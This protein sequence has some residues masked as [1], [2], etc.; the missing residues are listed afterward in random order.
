MSTSV[1]IELEELQ[2]M[3][4]E[5]EDRTVARVREELSTML[6]THLKQQAADFAKEIKIAVKDAWERGLA[7][8]EATAEL[9]AFHINPEAS[10]S[11][12]TSRSRC[13][14]PTPIPYSQDKVSQYTTSPFESAASTPQGDE[15]SYSSPPSTPSNS[16]RM[17]MS[18]PLSAAR[19]LKQHANK[20]RT[21]LP[22][23][24][25]RSEN[26]DS[27]SNVFTPQQ[28]PSLSPSPQVKKRATLPG[29]SVG[30]YDEL[31][32]DSDSD[33]EEGSTIPPPLVEDPVELLPLAFTQLPTIEEEE[34]SDD[35]GD[36]MED[37]RPTHTI[38]TLQDGDLE[39]EDAPSPEPQGEVSGNTDDTEMEEQGSENGDAEM[40][41]QDDAAAVTAT[42]A[43]VTN[44]VEMGDLVVSVVKPLP[45]PLLGKRKAYPLF[46]VSEQVPEAIQDNLALFTSM[47]GQFHRLLE[48]QLLEAVVQVDNLVAMQPWLKHFHLATKNIDNWDLELVVEMRDRHFSRFQ[49]GFDSEFREAFL[50]VN[51]VLKACKVMPTVWQI[52]HWLDDWVLPKLITHFGDHMEPNQIDNTADLSP[53]P[54]KRK[55]ALY[56][57]FKAIARANLRMVLCKA[58][59]SST[60]IEL[61][62]YGSRYLPDG[63]PVGWKKLQQLATKLEWIQAKRAMKAES[64]ESVRVLYEQKIGKVVTEFGASS[65]S[66]TNQILLCKQETT[67]MA[68]LHP[69]WENATAYIN[70]AH[71]QQR[72]V[73][74]D[75]VLHLLYHL[76]KMEVYKALETL[77]LSSAP[78][79]K[80]VAGRKGTMRE[81]FVLLS[82]ADEQWTAIHGRSI[83]NDC[84]DP[85]QQAK[86]MAA[87]LELDIMKT[88]EHTP[89]TSEPNEK[90]YLEQ[91]AQW[92]QNLTSHPLETLKSAA[93]HHLGQISIPTIDMSNYTSQCRQIPLP[94]P[95]ANHPVAIYALPQHEGKRRLLSSSRTDNRLPQWVLTGNTQGPIAD[96]DPMN[97][98]NE[99]DA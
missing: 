4:R 8:G 16:P 93:L 90:L 47:G 27:E 6:S 10:P 19:R 86:D 44:D 55:E 3:F 72:L 15:L 37:A 36:Q 53:A 35:G 17:A 94:I 2:R 74:D 65:T 62:K 59:D 5:S 80:A 87:H 76:K 48:E 50:E 20:K 25:D 66:L 21:V 9:A 92:R 69:R 31:V 38:S 24:E 22:G 11:T 12:P 70:D 61:S 60:S 43:T 51:S 68:E 73:P 88:I 18:S 7:H 26:K 77:Q 46:K 39:I 97:D 23:F 45:R 32:E 14:P 54:Q 34:A 58:Q 1:T 67:T 42:T 89:Q 49:N 75:G 13:S 41:D 33:E 81:L 29:F 95:H 64:A 63:K 85:E 56:R 52:R 71:S 98:E 82:L 30:P 91:A 83:Y 84:T 28:L 99:M 57:I 96:P 78:I 40:D 79:T